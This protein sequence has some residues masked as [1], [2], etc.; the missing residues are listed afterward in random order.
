MQLLKLCLILGGTTDKTRSGRGAGG[1]RPVDSGIIIICAWE[2][3]LVGNTSDPIANPM[4]GKS[5]TEFAI[6]L[7]VAS[8]LLPLL[9]SLLLP[10]L[11]EEYSCM[12]EPLFLPLPPCMCRS[13][14]QSNLA[15]QLHLGYAQCRQGPS[16]A[17]GTGV[18]RLT[19]RSS[20]SPSGWSFT[21][22]LS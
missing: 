3:P 10:E 4:R 7:R 20:P 1:K 17:R 19:W 5:K 21:R 11:L 13:F 6:F 22:R 15:T 12:V 9:L 14:I 16:R 8:I 18:C 2:Q